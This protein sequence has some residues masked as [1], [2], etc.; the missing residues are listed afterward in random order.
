M[1]MNKT[2]QFGIRAPFYTGSD[3][4]IVGDM[5]TDGSLKTADETVEDALLITHIAHVLYSYAEL[6][7]NS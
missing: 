3:W 1:V 5:R 7:Q 2:A 6:S 4:V